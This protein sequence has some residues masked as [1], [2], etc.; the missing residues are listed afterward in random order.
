[1]KNF[2]FKSA[3]AVSVFFAVICLLSCSKQDKR[4]VMDGLVQGT[5]YHIVFYAQDTA[6][7][8]QDIKTIFAD[9][10]SS[11]SLW[12]EKSTLSRVNNNE[13]VLLDDIF[14][15]NFDAAMKFSSLTDG[16]FDITVGELVRKHGF[17]NKNREKL[18]DSQVDSLLQFVG[19]DNISIKDRKLIKKYPQ[20]KLDFNAIAQGYTSDTIASYF[21]GRDIH[22]FIVDVGGEVMCGNKKPDGS[23]W[24]V[25]IEQVPPAD[26]DSDKANPYG[27]RKTQQIIYLENQ[28]VVTSGNYRKFYIENGVKYSHTIDPKTGKPVTHS[29]LSA[30]VIAEDATTADA[31][32]TAFMVMGLEKAQQFLANHKEYTAYLIYSDQDGQMQTWQSDNF[33]KYTEKAK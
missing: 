27:E 12:V 11:L 32:A 8:K 20:T 22:S 1:M 28:S 24:A 9:I 3:V 16:A 13:D 25:G 26:G 4:I 19:Y 31:L 14:I 10:D 21:R 17:A 30:S 5:Y 18:T 7:I 29:L 2:L 23:K 6:G 15:A 33:G